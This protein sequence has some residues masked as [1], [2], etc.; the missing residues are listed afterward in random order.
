MDNIT[1]IIQSLSGHIHCIF[2][3]IILINFCIYALYK[4]R[5][6]NI[7]IDDFLIKEHHR[8]KRQGA[9][10][11]RR[12]DGLNYK[13]ARKNKPISRHVYQT[14]NYED[15]QDTFIAQN[16]SYITKG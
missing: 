3:T 8:N 2:G 4:F 12:I 7:I 14:T 10:I 5:Q 16:D 13:F 9:H 6:L 11:N 1:I 15:L